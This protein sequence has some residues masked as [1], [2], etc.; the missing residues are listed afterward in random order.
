[1]KQ[2]YFG[3]RKLLS[4]YKQFN[5]TFQANEGNHSVEV[6]VTPKHICFTIGAKVYFYNPSSG[7]NL[8]VIPGSDLLAVIPTVVIT[9]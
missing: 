3:D 7:Q 2:R 4:K 6:P 1:M 9:L 8:I 5:F